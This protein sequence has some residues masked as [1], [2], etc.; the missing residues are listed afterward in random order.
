[1]KSSFVEKPAPVDHLLENAAD[2]VS[3]SLDDKSS[4]T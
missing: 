2:V 1:M 3:E 4:T